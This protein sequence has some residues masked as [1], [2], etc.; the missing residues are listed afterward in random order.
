MQ[1]ALKGESSCLLKS[2][3]LMS[4]K[5]KLAISSPFCLLVYSNFELMIKAKVFLLVM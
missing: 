4:K 2:A 1:S 5:G 3:V